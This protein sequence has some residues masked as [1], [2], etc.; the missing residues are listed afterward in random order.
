ML[1]RELAEPVYIV[2]DKLRRTRPL[3]L[4]LLLQPRR[5]VFEVHRVPVRKL[6]SYDVVAMDRA[7]N[8][9]LRAPGRLL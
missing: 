8:A 5:P 6:A 1:D 2:G 4:L 7:L 9:F 3:V